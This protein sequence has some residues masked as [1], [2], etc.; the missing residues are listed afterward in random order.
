[1]W[2]H[3]KMTKKNLILAVLYS[4]RVKIV[5][6]QIHSNCLFFLQNNY[7]ILV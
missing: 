7:F 6:L 3:L 5:C 2:S 4:Y 1:V